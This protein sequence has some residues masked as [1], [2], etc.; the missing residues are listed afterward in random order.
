[1][2]AQLDRRPA[3]LHVRYG[4]SWRRVGGHRVTYRVNRPVFRARDSL[5]IDGDC[6]I[7]P[8]RRIWET[9]RESGLTEAPGRGFSR[10]VSMGGAPGRVSDSKSVLLSDDAPITELEEL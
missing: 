6:G 9:S 2:K 8:T 4:N 10:S 5:D 3:G 1:R 7:T